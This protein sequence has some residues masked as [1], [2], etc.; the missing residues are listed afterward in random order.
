MHAGPMITFTVIVVSPGTPKRLDH[1]R[2]GVSHTPT[3]NTRAL[4]LS[5]VA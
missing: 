4:S 3:G 2:R 5:L 1:L